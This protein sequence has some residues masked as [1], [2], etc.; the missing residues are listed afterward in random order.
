MSTPA[1]TPD[2]PV[3]DPAV[4]RIVR[5]LYAL[6]L[7]VLFGAAL[8]LRLQHIGEPP[9]DFFPGWQYYCANRAHYLYLLTNVNVPPAQMA[10]AQRNAQF[11]VEPP[12]AERLAV[13]AYNLFARESLTIP[14]VLS[15]LYWLIGGLFL[16]LL[17]AR[18]FSALGGMASLAV[19]LFH[20]FG[21]AASRAFQPD[22]LMVML[23]L[24]ALYYIWRYGEGRARG[25]L[26]RAT[27]FAA[28]AIYVKVVAAPFLLFA[29]AAVH[30]LREDETPF[31]RR[32]LHPQAWLFAGGALLLAVIYYLNGLYGAGFLR[33]TAGSVGSTA[34]LRTGEFWLNLLGQW[35][36]V[37]GITTIPVA[38]LATCLVTH[39]VARGMLWALWLAYLCYACLFPYGVS[40]HNYYQLPLLCIIALS[41]GSLLPTALPAAGRGA[42][43]VLWVL[44]LPVGLYLY[45]WLYTPAPWGVSLALVV[46]VALAHLLGRRLLPAAARPYLH[47]CWIIY[48]L[49][50]LGLVRPAPL[51][52]LALLAGLALLGALAVRLVPW[53]RARAD[54]YRYTATALCAAFVLIAGFQGVYNDARSP[55]AWQQAAKQRARHATVPWAM[56]K[57]G[58]LTNHSQKIIELQLANGGPLQ[59]YGQVCSV[60]WPTRIDMMA[61]EMRG[62]PAIPMEERFAR[63]MEQ[64]YEYFVITDRREEMYQMDLLMMLDASFECVG[65]TDQFAIFDLRKPLAKP[66]AVH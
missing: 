4:L 47:G 14:R 41:L 57:V 10:I 44:L 43:G 30:L 45:T 9:L 35:N 61:N 18:V 63:V 19:Y 6:A 65:A 34:M 27:L 56:A 53:L 50:G 15:V 28:A 26:I 59:Y 66:D 42:L 60:S 5:G 62:L 11:N 12:V 23:I 40:T 7:V 31:L 13:M 3:V 1:V 17:T 29:F 25:H 37:F 52:T 51:V 48:L 54:A 21:I 16:Y 58:E 22:P 38:L 8:V 64:G 2:A 39:R 46:T 32:L 24:G 55:A 36:T 20:P 33:G 49:F